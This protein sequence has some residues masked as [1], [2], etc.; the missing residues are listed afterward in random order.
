MAYTNDRKFNYPNYTTNHSVAASDED[1]AA[2]ATGFLSP[3]NAY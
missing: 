2:A 3:F 1:A